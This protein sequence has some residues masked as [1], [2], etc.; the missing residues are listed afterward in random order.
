MGCQQCLPLSVFQLK[1]KHCRKPHCRDGSCRYVWAKT[2]LTSP[3]GILQIK[4]TSS[5][6]YTGIPSE[7]CWKNSWIQLKV[8]RPIVCIA[9]GY[10]RLEFFKD[11]FRISA[12]IPSEFCWKKSSGIQR[13]VLRPIDCNDWA[14][15]IQNFSRILSEILPEFRW[16]SVGKTA[17]F[18]LKF[19]DPLIAMHRATTI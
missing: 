13:K 9:S 10:N 7:F 16:N 12:W 6:I 15:T 5:R 2:V 17:E 11:S 19:K 18:S 1:G 8:Q 3:V 14:T 4:R